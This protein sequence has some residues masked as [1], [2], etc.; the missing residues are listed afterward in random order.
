MQSRMERILS[1]FRQ[2]EDYMEGRIQQG[3]QEY[4]MDYAYLHFVDKE[5]HPLPHVQ[6]EAKTSLRSFTDFNPSGMGGL[7][8]S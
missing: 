8:H 6:V 3:I 2:Q 1:A 4:R 7:C 5:G